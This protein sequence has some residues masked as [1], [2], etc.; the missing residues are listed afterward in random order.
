MLFLFFS[1][2]AADFASCLAEGSHAKAIEM[3]RTML[4]EGE[5][6]DKIQKYSGLSLYEIQ[7]L[8]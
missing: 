8:K 2:F 1:R 5:S 3:A 6:I 4:R 7:N